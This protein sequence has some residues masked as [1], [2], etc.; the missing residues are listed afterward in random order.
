[1]YKNIASMQQKFGHRYF[2]F[3]PLT[4]IIPQDIY[5]LKDQKKGQ[6]YILK[7][8]AKSQGKGIKIIDDVTEVF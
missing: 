3:V 5:L 8:S 4:Y 1:M 6:L 2:S 7:P